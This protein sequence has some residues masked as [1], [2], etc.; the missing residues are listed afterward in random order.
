M[1]TIITL[2]FETYYSKDYGLKKYT[3]EAYIRDKQFQTIGFAYKVNDGDTHWVTGSDQHIAA[4]LKS[5]NIPNA[6]LICH[7]MAFDGAILAWR[8]GI[9]PKYYIDTLSMARPVTGLTV[10]GSLAALTKKYLLE[11]EPKG[12][13]VVNALG[14]RREMFPT[15]QLA[16]YGEYCKHDVALTY[17]LYHVLKQWNPPRE[18]Y[19]QDLMI[20]M[21]TDP[22]LKLDK[23]V[24]QDHLFKVQ[25]NKRK[26]MDKIDATVG[27]DALMSN[28]KFAAVLK[29]L[30]VDAPM[31]ISLKTSKEAF[32]FSKT[33]AEFKALL[34]H[35]NPA[36]QALVAARLGIKSTLEETRTESFLGI[37]QRGLLPILLNYWGAHT[38]RASGGDKMNLQ[39]LPRGGALRRAIT[40]PENH[41]LV[42]SDSAQIEARVVAWLAGQ[43]DLVEDFRNN[44][45]IYS[46]FAS[47][48]YGRPV[49]RKRKEI[50]ENGKEFNPDKSEGFVGKT[51]ILGL[52]YGMG[53]DKFKATLKI[54]QG[55]VSVDM[56]LSDAQHAVTLY[57]TKYAMIAALWKSAQKA[58][59]KMAS[60]FEAEL[61]VGIALRCTPEGIHLP[62]GTM[63]RYPNLRR[64]AEGFEYDGRYGP[65]NIYGG[66]VVENVVQGLARIVVFDQMA[67]IDLEMRTCDNPEAGARYKVALTVHDE[68]VCVV[69]KAVGQWCLEFMLKTMS[70]PPKWCATLPVSCEGDIGLN[71]ADAK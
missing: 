39:N 50:D 4:T 56:P 19:I 49:D 6:Y 51:S 21:F 52:G 41:V 2:D 71:Y 46:S 25:D 36:V 65:V 7:N 33:D 9:I 64:T 47:V 3:T 27:R 29:Q 70:V 68:V 60:G 55:G 43:D 14:L 66:K 32:A 58:L 37:E 48:V 40:V 11:M 38:G 26:L 63:I 18:M 62:N 1:R 20:R 22:V 34:E 13:E 53:A 54:G 12:T 30:G 15:T 61:G 35:P 23:K 28:P 67:K 16:A 44:V 45:D 57:R 42:A 17:A 31:K 8:Y 5:L 10:G 24:L 59:D 69:P